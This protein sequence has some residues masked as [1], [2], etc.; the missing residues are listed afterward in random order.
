MPLNQ[1]KKKVSIDLNIR[2]LQINNLQK[3]MDVL[4][5]WKQRTKAIDTK[6]QRL[7]PDKPMAIFDEKFQMKTAID[8]D[9]I[10]GKFAKKQS[11]LAV[12]TKDRSRLL[13]EAD[14]DLG[15]YAND[16]TAQKDRLMLRNCDKDPEAFIEI[17][18]K[19]KTLEES[20]TPQRNRNSLAQSGRSAH[21]A[22]SLSL[23]AIEEKNSEFDQREEYE[24]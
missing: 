15:K 6:V 4:I 7:G 23:A 24:N 9:N 2:A 11:I 3:E 1:I 19:A 14:F 10:R 5:L 22:T 12:F 20:T 8:W 13:G 17:Y 21:Y 16:A 18:I